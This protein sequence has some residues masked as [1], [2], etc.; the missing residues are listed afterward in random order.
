MIWVKISHI[1][2]EFLEIFALN[3]KKLTTIKIP[4][5]DHSF[6]IEEILV[7]FF[8]NYNEITLNLGTIFN[9]E[10]F[11]YKASLLKK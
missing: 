6:S 5:F 4:F 10:S 8:D 7:S 2:Y 3:D 9:T 11:W 1:Y